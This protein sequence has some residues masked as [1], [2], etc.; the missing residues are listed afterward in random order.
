MD[1]KIILESFL[2]AID[3]G[4]V[5]EALNKYRNRWMRLSGNAI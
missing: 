1:S 4:A 2:N 3:I 5:F